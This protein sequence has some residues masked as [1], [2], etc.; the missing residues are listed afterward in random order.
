MHFTK[1]LNIFL[2]KKLMLKYCD[3]QNMPKISWLGSK[4]KF[5]VKA[6][7]GIVQQLYK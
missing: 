6:C 1:C 4:N 5:C 2:N 3:D 7:V